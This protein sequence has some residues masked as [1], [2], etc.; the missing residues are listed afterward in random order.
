MPRD[1]HVM[2]PLRHWCS[3]CSWTYVYRPLAL[4]C[5]I[6]VLYSLYGGRK[7][8]LVDVDGALDYSDRGLSEGLTD[9][10][11]TA[12]PTQGTFTVVTIY[13]VSCIYP[14]SQKADKYITSYC[15]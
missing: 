8:I 3:N 2:S 1:E 12:I 7:R 5:V 13:D 11:Y 4:V 6:F 15:P 9:S 10:V 14:L